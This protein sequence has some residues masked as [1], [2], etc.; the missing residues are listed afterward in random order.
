[1][2][3]NYPKGVTKILSQYQIA[4]FSKWTICYTQQKNLKSWVT[5]KN[6]IYKC[7]TFEGIKTQ[8]EPN[9]QEI[10]VMDYSKYFGIGKSIHVF[11]KKVTN[12]Q[13][14]EETS[15]A[16]YTKR[17]Q[18]R[19]TATKG[20][21]SLTKATWVIQSIWKRRAVI[22]SPIA[23]SRRPTKCAKF[24]MWVSILL[25]RHWFIL[26]IT[27]NIKNNPFTKRDIDWR[28]KY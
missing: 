23:I 2:V 18:N 22:D 28:W 6:F 5:I 1:M 26:E 12:N 3:W 17:Q 20:V 27:N 9:E 24:N 21:L 7:N 25:M 16:M 4:V 8:F 14:K 15:C 11:G 19:R 13:P 10:R